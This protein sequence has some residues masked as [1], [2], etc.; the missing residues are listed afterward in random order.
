MTGIVDI[1][2]K[3]DVERRAVARGVLDLKPETLAAIVAK[4]VEKGDVLEVARVAAIQ[5]VKETPRL[6]PLCHPI[7]VTSIQADLATTDRTVTA[8][9][10]VKARYK[11]GVEMEA[12]TGVTVALLTVWD[13][14]KP[15]E[16][17]R[18]GQYPVARI[19]DVR[20]LVKEKRA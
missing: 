11:T 14:V 19:R 6:L 4:K 3:P 12:L 5:A 15:L 9:V 16:K 8:T 18:D 20:V 13:M 1:G 2:G 17:D 10:E 7:P